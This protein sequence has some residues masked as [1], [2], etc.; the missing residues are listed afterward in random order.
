MAGDAND[1]R[2]IAHRDSHAVEQRL[3]IIDRVA[4]NGAD[5]AVAGKI[6]SRVEGVGLAAVDLVYHDEVRVPIAAI[7]AA[8][9]LAGE[10]ALVKHL[11]SFEPEQPLEQAQRAIVRSVIDDN[12]LE[13]RIIERQQR[14]DGGFNQDLLIECRRD[15]AHWNREVALRQ[16]VVVLVLVLLHQLDV[17]QCGAEQHDGK[18]REDRHQVGKA[19]GDHDEREGLKIHLR[20]SLAAGGRSTG[21]GHAPARPAAAGGGRRPT[22]EGRRPQPVS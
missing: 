9:Q 15:H 11:A 22:S 3:G 16:G 7:D 13:L 2:R 8:H 19:R 17:F 12:H 14:P 18:R 10:P 6:Q 1:R 21:R 20:P 5:V 4:V